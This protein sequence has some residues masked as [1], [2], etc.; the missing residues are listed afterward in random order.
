MV[1]PVA[2]QSYVCIWY[3]FDR[4]NT[5]G[6]NSSRLVICETRNRPHST[7]LRTNGVLEIANN[8]CLKSS[9]MK[10]YCLEGEKYTWVFD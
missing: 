8:F 2:L 7:R 5:D 9:R 10:T 1:I 3:V 6:P 4:N